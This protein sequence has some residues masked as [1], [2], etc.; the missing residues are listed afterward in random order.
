MPGP[1]V[2]DEQLL[3]T[4]KETKA[5]NPELSEYKVCCLVAR[6]LG[7]SSV[8][9]V[10]S[11]IQRVSKYQHPQYGNVRPLKTSD[12]VGLRTGYRYTAT[13]RGLIIRTKTGTIRVLSIEDFIQELQ[14][15]KR[16]Y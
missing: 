16:I 13:G 11:R 7:L 8:S 15:C 6:R 9:S 2:T 3:T 12:Y 4:Y 5:R 10:L 1:K 14:D